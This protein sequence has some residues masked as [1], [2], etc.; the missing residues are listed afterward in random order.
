MLSD[1]EKEAL[2]NFK[3]EY[4]TCDHYSSDLIIEL[5]DA[6]II[7]NLIEKQSKEIEGLKD[8]NKELEDTLKQTQNSWYEDTKVIEKQ[9]KE[10]EELKNITKSYD[11]FLGTE[12]IVIA[13]KKFFVNGYF[14]ENYVSKDKIKAKIEE[15]KI[16]RDTLLENEKEF[17]RP[18][19]TYDLKRNDYC[20]KMLQSLLE[21]EFP[22][23]IT[24]E[25]LE[26]RWKE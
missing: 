4:E 11:S 14:R 13:D 3:S 16:V 25:E 24:K 20:E 5:D 21:K 10:I 7:L 2:R 26:E 18:M 17:N 19:M 8:K 23:T 15:F 12:K 1:E 22:T 9:S 6:E